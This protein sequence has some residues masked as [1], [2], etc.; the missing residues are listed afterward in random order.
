MRRLPPLAFGTC[1]CELP[2]AER[3]AAALEEIIAA[4]T[5]DGAAASTLVAGDRKESRLSEALEAD[6]ALLLWT[7]SAARLRGGGQLQT[8]AEAADWLARHAREILEWPAGDPEAVISISG[9]NWG[10][11]AESEDAAPAAETAARLA[12]LESRFQ[13]TLQAEKLEALAEFAAGAGHEINN[14]LTVIAGRAQLFLHGETDAEK[15]RAL[16]LIERQAMRVYEMIADM[17][18]FARPPQLHRVPLDAAKIIGQIAADAQ[19]AA[20][21]QETE[22]L[23]NVPAGPLEIEVD[24][25]QLNVAVRALCQ[26]ALEAL[27]HGGRMEIE[28]RMQDGEL[29]IRVADNGPGV[30]PEQRRHIFDPFFSARQAGRGLGLGLSK[31]WRIVTNHGGRMEVENPPQGAAFVIVLPKRKGLEIGD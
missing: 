26:N 31:C 9:E 6:P 20:A 10:G 25:A 2:L 1:R 22:F 3:S 21:R 15:R 5:A 30:S 24:P 4:E 18:L 27:G 8:L 16:A 29:R 19:A 14:P 7:I 23:C 28:T 12:A 17:M 11:R 13:E